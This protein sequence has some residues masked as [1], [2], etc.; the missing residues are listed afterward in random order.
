[1]AVVGFLDDLR[2]EARAF[3]HVIQGR[4]QRTGWRGA[5]RRK[6]SYPTVISIDTEQLPSVES[7]RAAEFMTSEPGKLER[8]EDDDDQQNR[9]QEWE[10]PLPRVRAP[11]PSPVRAEGKGKRQ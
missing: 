1:M 5:D 11:L 10:P 2:L 9:G 6:F 8:R 4:R 3:G 7:G